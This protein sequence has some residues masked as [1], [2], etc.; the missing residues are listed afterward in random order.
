MAKPS[1][2]RYI[3]EAGICY[4]NI[5]VRWWVGRARIKV[6]LKLWRACE[7]CNSK[8]IYQQPAD[9]LTGIR[10]TVRITDLQLGIYSRSSI[11]PRLSAVF[12]RH[13]G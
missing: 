11:G 8:L 10:S 7:K 3:S 6:N 12:Y 2:D 4:T 5:A 1:I 9:L 13:G